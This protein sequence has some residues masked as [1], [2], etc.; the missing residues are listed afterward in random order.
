MSA[1]SDTRG[2]IWTGPALRKALRRW[3]EAESQPQTRLEAVRSAAEVVM[4]AQEV[5]EQRVLEARAFRKTWADIAA[6]VGITRQSAHRRWRHLDEP[7][8][9]LDRQRD[10]LFYPRK[11]HGWREDVESALLRG[12]EHFVPE[13]VDEPVE[14]DP[15]LW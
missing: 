2:K 9:Q 7:A 13:A 5:L 8:A 6:Q 15:P 3:L 4:L 14:P 1:N 10:R 11:W 12:D